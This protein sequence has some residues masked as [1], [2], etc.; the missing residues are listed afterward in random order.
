VVTGTST[1]MHHFVP[2]YFFLWRGQVERI[3][4][5][6]LKILLNIF[7]IFALYP[8]LNHIFMVL[9]GRDDHAYPAMRNVMRGNFPEKTKTVINGLFIPSQLCAMHDDDEGAP[10]GG[11]VIISIFEKIVLPPVPY[12]VPDAGSPHKITLRLTIFI[13][14]VRALCSCP[15][16][17]SQ[18]Y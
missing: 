18:N 7:H 9:S 6:A 5:H 13:V 4:D 2:V 12:R 1:V 8:V 15:F 17:Q 3:C 11:S 16:L 10:R 14:R